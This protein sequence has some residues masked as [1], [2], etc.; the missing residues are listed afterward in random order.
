M[1]AEILGL[2]GERSSDGGLVGQQQLPA[3]GPLHNDV[4]S[5]VQQQHGGVLVIR[6]GAN[7][8]GRNFLSFSTIQQECD[9][10]TKQ[11]GED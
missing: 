6:R 10:S 2:D 5:K 8:R 3:D 9:G 7:S 1:A 11:L 4:V